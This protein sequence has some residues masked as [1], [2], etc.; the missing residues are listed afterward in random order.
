MTSKGTVGLAAIWKMLDRCAPGHVRKAREHNWAILF[1]G[2]YYHGFPLGKHG[3]RHNPSIQIGHV[4]N[5]VRFFGIED[6]AR[7]QI[8]SLK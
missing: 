8:P 5:M 7:G 1:A 2:R 6:C 3:A 4:R